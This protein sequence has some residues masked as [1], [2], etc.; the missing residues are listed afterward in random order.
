MNPFSKT[1]VAP[2]VLR[3]IPIIAKYQAGTEANFTLY[4]SESVLFVNELTDPCI[5]VAG[6]CSVM[7]KSPLL[8]CNKD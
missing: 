2:R 7:L 3:V 6:S 8:V 1:P 4:K 5:W